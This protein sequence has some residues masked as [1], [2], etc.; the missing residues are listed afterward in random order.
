MN[1]ATIP[2]SPSEL[3]HS[4]LARWAIQ[5]ADKVAIL[6]GQ[7]TLSFAELYAR[8]QQAAL[9]LEL[10]RAPATVLIDDELPIQ[11]RV[12]DFLATIASG[13]CAAVSYPDWAPATRR[14][15]LEL[16][17]SAPVSCAPPGPNTP[18][19]VG[20]TSGSTGL[21]KGFRRHHRS[22]V[23]S[24]RIC[25]ETFRPDACSR[26]MV[27][28]RLS[29][30]LFLFGILFGL[31]SGA[32]VVVQERFSAAELIE[33][34]ARGATPSLVAVPSQLLML[35]ELA[36]RRH[37]AAMD[38]VRLIMIS[39]AR[40]ARE[41]T[42]A[43]Q[44][45]FPR[46]RIIEF[47]GTSE[48]SFISWMQADAAVPENV[49]GYPFVNVDIDIRDPQEADGSGL[50]YVRSPMLFM[51]YIGGNR[52]A[53]AALRADEW[54]SVRDVGRFDAQGRLLLIGR[55]NRMVVTQG[56]N[57]FPEEVETVLAAY[58]SIETASVHGLPHP[59]R[60]QQVVAIV[61]T[62]TGSAVVKNELMNWCREHLEAYKVPRHVYVCDEWPWTAS[63]K[64]DHNKLA[65]VL[66]QHIDGSRDNVS[67][68]LH[69]LH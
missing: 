68:C 14:S 10:S 3:V 38:S 45:L 7:S 16:L 44:A 49:V 18:F 56:K 48:T 33:T 67:P 20:F 69:R 13:R 63:G 21:P 52:D 53:T 51:D 40:W 23:E 11:N 60:G 37:Q 35:L 55:Q 64:T 9:T 59:V 25:A 62:Q 5:R 6:E 46:A 19:Y 65:Q 26:L 36:T 30:S 47:Y 34:L 57:L 17:D 42:P 58:P 41:H 32:G 39:G 61:R 8:V 54:I 12:I 2:E 50:I 28:G 1:P 27:P 15:V 22:W 66:E 4:S 31:W 24:F 29:H 43:L